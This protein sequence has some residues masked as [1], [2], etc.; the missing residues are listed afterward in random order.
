MQPFAELGKCAFHQCL[1]PPAPPSPEKDRKGVDWALAAAAAAL[2]GEAPPPRA[3]AAASCLRVRSA[4][5]SCAVSAAAEMLA[6]CTALSKP[7]LKA[8]AQP[9]T[10]DSKP[11]DTCPAK[12]P[13]LPTKRAL[14]RRV[15]EGVE[16]GEAEEEVVV[17]TN[18][19]E[20]TPSP[21]SPPRKLL[22]LAVDPPE[23]RA[24]AA[25]T[26]SPAPVITLRSRFVGFPR[27][28]KEPSSAGDVRSRSAATKATKASRNF[29]HGARALKIVRGAVRSGM[30]FGERTSSRRICVMKAGGGAGGGLIPEA[31]EV[32]EAAA[33]A[34]LAAAPPPS[35]SV[36]CAEA[37][38]DEVSQSPTLAVSL[39]L[40]PLMLKAWRQM[41]SG[42]WE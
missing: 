4:E 16:E 8:P 41:S 29:P 35:P 14:R 21:P 2:A 10:L 3:A 38:A 27:S 36:D 37:A 25:S 22:L 6:A 39:A 30:R 26:T 42:G 15:E 18:L 31:W 9:P 28:S 13:K 12:R 34:A 7:V 1:A 40:T 33:D 19:P 24:F 5:I 23:T 32:A 17:M 11:P 20:G